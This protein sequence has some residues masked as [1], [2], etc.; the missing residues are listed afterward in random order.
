MSP[1]FSRHPRPSLYQWSQAYFKLLHVPLAGAYR[2]IMGLLH[3]KPAPKIQPPSHLC[4]KGKGQRP[5]FLHQGCPCCLWW[6]TATSQQ[7]Q[8]AKMWRFWGNRGKTSWMQADMQK[9]QQ[10][11]LTKGQWIP[12]KWAG[13]EWLEVTREKVSEKQ[14]VL[15]WRDGALCK[16]SRSSMFIKEGWSWILNLT[17]VSWNKKVPEREAIGPWG[18][19][20]QR[21]WQGT[22]GRGWACK[23]D[24][25]TRQTRRNQ[26]QSLLQ[27]SLCISSNFEDQQYYTPGRCL[28]FSA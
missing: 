24:A 2:C 14:S 20:K 28:F 7:N 9:W 5:L 12:D 4:K 17:H 15:Q 1:K 26:D 27:Q 8:P 21:V 22:A 18:I 11:P 3:V 16:S 13:T 6:C 23:V 10:V 19:A 25:E